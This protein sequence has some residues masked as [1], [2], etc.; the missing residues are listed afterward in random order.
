MATRSMTRS[1]QPSHS[2]S[3][4]FRFVLQTLIAAGVQPLLVNETRRHDRSIASRSSAGNHW[5]ACESPNRITTVD[6][7]GSP[8]A[9]SGMAVAGWERWQPLP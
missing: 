9:H 4:R 7:A 8:K 3:G 5:A 2:V 6:D 1:R